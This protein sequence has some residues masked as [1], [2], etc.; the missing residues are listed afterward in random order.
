[1][2][3]FCAVIANVSKISS[4]GSTLGIHHSSSW[5]FTW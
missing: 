1:M 2:H 5:H 3:R 4:Q